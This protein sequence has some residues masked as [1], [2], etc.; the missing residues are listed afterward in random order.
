MFVNPA[1]KKISSNSIKC[2]ITSNIRCR[3]LRNKH[4]SAKANRNEVIAQSAAKY[5]LYIDERSHRIDTRHSRINGE[6]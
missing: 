4:K 6:L 3:K 2:V 5:D 1:I